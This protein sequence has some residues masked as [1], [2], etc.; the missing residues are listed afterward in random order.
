MTTHTCQL[1]VLKIRETWQVYN[2]RTLSRINIIG[3]IKYNINKAHD[4]DG[5]PVAML[6]IC[7][8]EIA[9]PLGIIFRKC[10]TTGMF[11]DVC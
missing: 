4:Y 8:D 5:I 7:A 3:I 1:L 2:G 11:P 6:Q 10:V 9:I